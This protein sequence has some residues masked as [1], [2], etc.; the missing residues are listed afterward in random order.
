MPGLMDTMRTRAIREREQRD[1]GHIPIIAL[2]RNAMKRSGDF[3]LRR[4]W[5]II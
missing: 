4:A 2:T 1:L 5:E 3:C